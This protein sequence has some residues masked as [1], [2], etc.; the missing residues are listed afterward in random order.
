M[1][2]RDPIDDCVHCG[3]CL[4]VCPT[5]VSWGQE[6]DSPRGRIDLLRGVRDGRIGE[7]SAVGIHLDRCLGC[8]ACMTA[9]PSGVRFDRILERGRAEIE[10]RLARAPSDRAHRDLIFSLFPRPGRLRAIAPLLWLYQATGLQWLLRRTG[11]MRLVSRRLAQLDAL[12]PR[13]RLS[14]FLRRLPARTPAAGKPRLRMALVEGCV[15]RIFF[16]HVNVATLRVLAAEGCEVLVPRG[17]GCCGALAVHAGRREE[18][19]VLARNLVEVFEGVE[20]DVV[21][22]NAA[23]CGSHMKELGHLLEDDPALAARA[24]A[25][26]ARVKDLSEVLAQLPPLAA[27]NAVAARVA[28]QPACHLHHA[29]GVKAAVP[30]LLRSVPGLDVRELQDTC[31]GSAGIYNL[32]QPSSSEEIGARKVESLLPIE[33]DVVATANPGCTLQLELLLRARGKRVP[34]VHFVE[35]LDASIRG[36]RP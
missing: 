25:L 22:V 19:R 15:Q 16:Q 12:L 26:A 11:I 20:A 23:G 34:V 3:F 2:G 5:Y 7:V 18:A 17:Q 14:G 21:V 33:P 6:M 28:Y 4:P 1:P 24:A 32:V 8:M 36:K 9:C 13:V 27:R 30:A 10:A 29:Q 31:C 35:L